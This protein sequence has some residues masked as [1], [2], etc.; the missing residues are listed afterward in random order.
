MA[1]PVVLIVFLA[2][3]TLF[4][5]PCTAD[6]ALYPG[7]RLSVGE[8]ITTGN[9]VLKMEDDCDLVLYDNHAIIWHSDTSGK[10]TG[11]YAKLSTY[12]EFV[13]NNNTDQSI[14]IGSAKQA[15]EASCVLILQRD[16][17]VVV[18]YD[19]LWSTNTEVGSVTKAL[20]HNMGIGNSV[21][22]GRKA[23]GRNMGIG[24]SV[25]PG[26]KALGRAFMLV[27]SEGESELGSMIAQ[28]VNE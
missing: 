7:D 4:T 20:G 11:C 6:S 1:I 25:K 14:W 13:I 12:G 2:I 18:Y 26:R 21:K 3:S 16:R 19:P 23:L 28:V 10:G 17:N 22:P 8:S 5:P 24:N 27:N 9:Y 15:E